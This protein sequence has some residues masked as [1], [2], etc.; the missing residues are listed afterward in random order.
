MI[1]YF[2]ALL[3]IVA[4][5]ALFVAVVLTTVTVSDRPPG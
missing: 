3:L 4:S 5:C 2:L 1:L